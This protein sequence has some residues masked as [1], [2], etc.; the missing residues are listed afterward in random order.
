MQQ[1][2]AGFQLDPSQLGI[3]E[4][5]GLDPSQFDYGNQLT[6]SMDSP[7]YNMDFQQQ[8]RGPSLN[9]NNWR[10]NNSFVGAFKMMFGPT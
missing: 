1:Q 3:G 8:V 7:N 4:S 5:M 9:F 2:M 6:Q 10:I